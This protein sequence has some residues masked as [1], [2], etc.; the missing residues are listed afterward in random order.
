MF[1]L[2]HKRAGQGIYGHKVWLIFIGK[3]VK[4]HIAN[5]CAAFHLDFSEC[6]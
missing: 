5:T 6:K 4:V 1:Q 3:E 2:P